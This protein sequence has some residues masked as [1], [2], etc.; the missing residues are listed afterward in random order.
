MVNALRGSGSSVRFTRCA[1]VGHD[2]WTRSYDNPERY[3]W[4]LSRRRRS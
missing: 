2:S 3:D 1:G 4:L